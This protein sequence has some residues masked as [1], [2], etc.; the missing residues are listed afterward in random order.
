MHVGFL[1]PIMLPPQTTE[2]KVVRK[3]REKG[4]SKKDLSREQFL[5]HAW[6]WTH[7]HGGIILDQLKKLGASCDWDRTA[8][9]L[10]KDYAESVIDAFIGC[11]RRVKYTEVR[12]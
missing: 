2:A 1:V 5:E 11:M 9:T 12:G 6:E 4:I 10:D 8:F 3:L 7:T